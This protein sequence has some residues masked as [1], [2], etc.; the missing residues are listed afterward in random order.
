MPNA[1][2]RPPAPPAATFGQIDK[3]A[4]APRRPGPP[5]YVEIA[6]R[7]EFQELRSRLHR[8]VFPMSA[9]FLI[10]YIGYVVLAAY[11]PEFMAIRLVGEINVG[12]V[13]G[14]GQFV[15]TIV[16][17]ALYLRYAAQHVDPRVRELHLD[18][19]GEEPR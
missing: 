17:T 5:D 4:P 19:T 12:L 16:I 1:T 14:I 13:L 2:Q 11:L 10:W 15:S 6:Q 7:P 18:V 9:A 8:F 3:S